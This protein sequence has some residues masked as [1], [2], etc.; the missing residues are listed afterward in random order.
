MP[1]S[2]GLFIVGSLLLLF[3]PDLGASP[4]PG[5]RCDRGAAGGGRREGGGRDG[6]LQTPAK[7]PVIKL[8]LTVRP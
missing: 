5:R 8:Y 4:V 1:Y 6:P 2:D 3:V 7:E